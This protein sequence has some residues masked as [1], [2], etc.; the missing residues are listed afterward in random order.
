MLRPLTSL[1]KVVGQGA[2]TSFSFKRK[3]APSDDGALLYGKLVAGTGFLRRFLD[4]F[5]VEVGVPT[6]VKDGA[7][8]EPSGKSNHAQ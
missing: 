7:S 5:I 2:A 1:F 8:G 6:S 3:R 4:C